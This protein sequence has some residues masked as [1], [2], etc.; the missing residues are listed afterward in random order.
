LVSK[1]DAVVPKVDFR[2][3]F[4]IERKFEQRRD[5]MFSWVHD[6]AIKLGFV[7]VVTKFNNRGVVE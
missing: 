1:V 5:H 6:L 2:I 4:T 7:V 3:E